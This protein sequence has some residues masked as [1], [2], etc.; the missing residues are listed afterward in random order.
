MLGG[1]GVAFIKEGHA[2]VVDPGTQESIQGKPAA[3]EVIGHILRL[4]GMRALVGNL[5]TLIAVVNLG[6]IA[7]LGDFDPFLV[8][9]LREAPE[10]NPVA[11]WATVKK[12]I[13]STALLH[14][15]H[16]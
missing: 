9:K 4:H 6:D 13:G 1:N 11:G 16:A 5:V 12:A 15:A 8:G 10:Q 2:G 7:L 14:V 3:P